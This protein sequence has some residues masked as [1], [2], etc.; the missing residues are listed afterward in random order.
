MSLADPPDPPQLPLD[1]GMH[2]LSFLSAE[3]RTQARVVCPEWR[4]RL[5]ENRDA[6]ERSIVP[7]S[8]VSWP[9]I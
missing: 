3:E 7:R 6:L 2:V 4:D 8:I 1:L 5:D 9:R